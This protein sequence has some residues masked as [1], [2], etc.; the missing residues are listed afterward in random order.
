MASLWVVNASPIIL[1]AKVGQVELLRRLGP[2]VAEVRPSVWR[3]R[4]ASGSSILRG[5]GGMPMSENGREL[6]EQVKREAS[7]PSTIPYTELP[8]AKPDSPLYHEW[9]YYRR[10]VGRLLAE[11]HEGR[12]ILIKGQVVIGLWD[13]RA[14]AK[15]VAVQRYLMQPCLIQQIRSREPLVRLPARLWGCQS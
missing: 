14:A 5:K 8:D 7:E 1:L 9:N 15:A 11:G 3:C 13:T 6:I 4:A 12:F 10:E 2:P